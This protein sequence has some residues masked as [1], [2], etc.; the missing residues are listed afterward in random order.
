[1]SKKQNSKALK[2]YEEILQRT[3]IN[4]KKMIK[5]VISRLQKCSVATRISEVNQCRL[6]LGRKKK[7]RLGTMMTKLKF[8]AEEA[9]YLFL[10]REITEV[11]HNLALLE[12][13]RRVEMFLRDRF[14]PMFSVDNISNVLENEHLSQPFGYYLNIDLMTLLD[15]YYRDDEITSEPLHRLKATIV[16]DLEQNTKT[17]NIVSTI[18]DATSRV[19]K[20][21]MIQYDYYFLGADNRTVYDISP[22]CDDVQRILDELNSERL[23]L[24]ALVLDPL[25]DIKEATR[26][27]HNQN[28][29]YDFDLEVFL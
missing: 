28:N 16:T 9:D 29:Y 4:D 15:N 1:M 24:F 6:S 26:L 23:A 19:N 2:Y 27:S 20:L 21:L 10:T 13:L 12:V 22:R 8:I 18:L 17:S 11:E 25:Y 5:Q 7:M 14:A 3:E